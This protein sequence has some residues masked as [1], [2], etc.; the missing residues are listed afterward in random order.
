MG[1]TPGTV[2]AT[3]HGRRLW[4]V[5]IVSV[6]TLWITRPFLTPVAWGTILAIAE[7]PL[8]RRAAERLPDH[9]TMIACALT[10]ATALLVL[11]PLSLAAVT[12]AGESQA[13][14][15]WIRG[16][17]VHGVPAPT[18]LASLPIAGSPL[19]S[20]WHQH[21]ATPQ[22]AHAL[23]GTVEAG[24]VVGWTRSIGLEVARQSGLFLVTLAV[25]A[26]LLVH[27][28][29]LARQ[30]RAIAVRTFDDF[31]GAFAD[32]MVDAVRSTVA[33]TL[34]VSFVE[35][36]LIGLG[37][38]IAGVPQPLLFALFTFILALIPF[39]AWAAFGI[40]SLLLAAGGHVLAAILL[41]LFGATVMTIGDNVVQPAVIGRAVK[42]PFVLAM[43]GVFG[44]IAML[45]LVGLFLGPV[46]MVA[47]MFV[48]QQ[49]A[50]VSPPAASRRARA[51]KG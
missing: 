20:W 11:I 24:R 26:T 10:L 13:A 17:D 42:L 2:G 18:W 8:A 36:G 45:G 15:D 51:S 22:G 21:L 32:R 3:L 5:G 47:F 1:T 12:L 29:R 14:L 9:R 37:Y 48:W 40:A 23:L 34:L 25:L 38:M 39:G 41:F 31:G 50:D 30:A 6:L 19:A 7:W 27:G 33:G 28:D 44:G 4:L 49:G 16:A 35:G 46:V 43:F